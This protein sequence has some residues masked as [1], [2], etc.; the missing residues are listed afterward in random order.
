[1]GR[2][3]SL[4]LALA[5]LAAAVGVAAA[6]PAPLPQ[7]LDGGGLGSTPPGSRWEIGTRRCTGANPNSAPLGG[8]SLDDAVLDPDA[9]AGGPW[10]LAY[11]PLSLHLQVD[12]VGI[13]D[14]GTDRSTDAN[15]VQVL[16]S[17]PWSQSGL[18]WTVEYRTDPTAARLGFLVTAVNPSGVDEFARVRIGTDLGSDNA[19]NVRGS[20]NTA[21]PDVDQVDRWFITSDAPPDDASTA[22]NQGDPVILHAVMSPGQVAESAAADRVFGDCVDGGQPGSRIRVRF[23][24]DVPAGAT[25]RILL[26]DELHPSGTS[27][28]SASATYDSPLSTADPLV[29]HLSAAELAEVVNFT[30]AAPAGGGG[31]GGGGGGVPQPSPSGS[32]A[33]APSPSGSAAPAPSPSGGAT[34]APS[35]SGGGGGAGAASPSPSPS[36]G[37]PPGSGMTP[38]PTPG[39]SPGATPTETPTEPETDV[40]RVAGATRVETAVAL[41]QGAFTSASTVVLARSDLPADALAGG[42][43]AFRLEA[44]LL[45]TPSHALAPVVADEIRRLGATTAIL[46]GG[47]AALGPQVAADVEALGLAVDRIAGGGR[48]GTARLIALR[49]GSSEHAYV[50]QGVDGWPDAIAVGPLAA[51]TGRPILLVEQFSASEPTLTALRELGATGV[52]VLGGTARIDD[53]VLDQLGE[54][55]ASVVRL[56]G[57]TRYATGA[58]VASAAVDAGMDPAVVWLATGRDFADALAVGPV[59]ARAGQVLLLVEGASVEGSAAP[60]TWL[61]ER[62]ALVEALRVVGGEAAVIADVAAAAA[63]AAT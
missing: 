50:A 5:L 54:T 60:L 55:G 25:R 45:L 37:G 6:A 57:P 21:D 14:N 48:A 3:T 33:P 23:E 19:T 41:S 30:F 49:L 2:R 8:I 53:A 16:R 13:V 51:V 40:D 43:L 24:L 61:R 58:L 59:V 42:P 28:Q 11:N 39:A 35:P 10:D 29:A 31:G 32:A 18:N 20:S 7:T 4:L 1:M 46:L 12:D 9:E 52:T 44:P 22:A 27:A 36:P 56:S 38:T 15:G 17:S 63:D 62:A 26:I 34:P 47:T